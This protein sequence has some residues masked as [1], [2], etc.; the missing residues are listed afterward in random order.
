VATDAV[1]TSFLAW[2]KNSARVSGK[3]VGRIGTI[4]EVGG[5]LAT[6]YTAY[7]AMNAMQQEYAYCME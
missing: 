7:Q 5:A 2:L 6:L 4:G 3:T 1:K